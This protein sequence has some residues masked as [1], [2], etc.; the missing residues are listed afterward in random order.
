MSVGAF[1]ICCFIPQISCCLYSLCDIFTL[2]LHDKRNFKAFEDKI[3]SNGH[4]PW[5][6]RNNDKHIHYNRCILS[7]GSGDII[8]KGPRRGRGGYIKV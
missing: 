4:D 5:C 3:D 2:E 8:T 6:A 7:G 1:T